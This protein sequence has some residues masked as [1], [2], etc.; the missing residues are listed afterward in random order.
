MSLP[1]ESNWDEY[2][3]KKDFEVPEFII[4]ALWKNYEALI[5]K[6]LHVSGSGLIVVELGGA[7]SCF[8]ERFKKAFAVTEYHIIDN[9]KLG[10][11]LFRHKGDTGTFLHDVDLLKA[12]LPKCL[13]ADIVFS[14]GLIEHFAPEDTQK[15]I[16]VHF[17]LTRSSGLVLMS[18][19]T[20]TLV[21]W[22]FRR[23]LERMGKFPPLFERPI[24]PEEVMP[25]LARFGTP[26]E[27]YKIWRAVLT[28]LITITRKS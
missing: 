12:D 16:D 24:S 3:S 28:Q 25:I 21:Y 27:T 13:S 15:I 18:F 10:L 2:Y 8:Y 7:N 14:A 17:E 23:F 22:T 4:N 1:N 26:L 9:N 6:H 20:P 11:E 19:P 5:R